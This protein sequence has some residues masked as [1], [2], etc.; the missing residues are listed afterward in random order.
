MSNRII[1]EVTGDTRGLQRAFGRAGRQ[2]E[3]FAAQSTRLGTSIRR[4]GMF[5]AAGLSALGFGQYVDDAAETV[6]KH[7]GVGGDTSRAIADLTVGMGQLAGETGKLNAKLL[8][9]A[10]LVAGAGLA[11]YELTSMF[12]SATGLD[13]KLRDVGGAAYDLAANL[14]L[15]NDPMKEFQ[16][17]AAPTQGQAGQIRGQARTMLQGG[18][19]SAQ[20]VNFLVR[21]YP[22]MA[23]RDIEVLSGARGT[24]NIAGGLHLHGVQN[25]RSLEQALA[26]RATTRPQT[27]RGR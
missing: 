25:V 15:V 14:G 19:T 8:G 22:Q 1:V 21:A 7:F 27:R 20:V 11:A 2:A 12:L 26:K 13:D 17:K 3:G 24:I 5:A 18:M 23:K 6:L 9:K 4:K 10:G 16:G